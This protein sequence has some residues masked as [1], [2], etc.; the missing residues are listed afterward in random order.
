MSYAGPVSRGRNAA[1][2]EPL[3]STEMSGRS[4]FRTT[5]P[6]R[7]RTLPGARRDAYLAFAAG[8][9]LGLTIG[10]GAAL[11]FAPQTGTDTRRAIVR[12][13]RRLSR[14]GSDAWDDLRDELSRAARR[15][16]QAFR[17][18]RQRSKESAAD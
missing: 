10:A 8:I 14:R 6:F 7:P 11:L 16:R 13:G 9:A 3:G 15:G 18:R 4:G 12:K 2:I 5:T 1:N 17:R